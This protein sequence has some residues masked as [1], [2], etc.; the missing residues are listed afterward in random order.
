MKNKLNVLFLLLF[1]SLMTSAQTNRAL[2]VGIDNYPETSG[3]PKIHG[4]NDAELIIPLLK[5]NGYSSKNIIQL[6][7]GQATKANILNAFQKLQTQSVKG[8][9]IYIHFSCHGQQ[10][11]DDD[12]DELDEL[13]EALIPY[14][15]DRRYKKG[16]YEGANH[17]RDD[18][19]ERLLNKIRTKIGATGNIIVVLDACHSGTGTREG[20]DE[21]FIRGTSYI[22]KPDN[23]IK[24]A[25]KKD[26]SKNR[27]I[28]N[29]QMASITV[30]SACKEDEKNYEHYDN[31]PQ[32]HYG[33]LSHALYTTLK[34][35]QT[36]YTSKQLAN[37]LENK[38]KT[39]FNE[40]RWK[41]TP[42]FE[43]TN[44]DNTLKF[45]K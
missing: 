24:P 38:M 5:A 13:D 8:D 35:N 27:L 39:M 32:K 23:Y 42:F 30:F 17:L 7:N 28:P 26:A 9:C 1:I 15:A 6:L 36:T 3:W 44:P 37:I 25:L 10:M 29:P 22:F 41:Q 34:N 16:L 12:G 31:R 21:E 4:A 14:D 18:E 11:A 20:D 19:L 40:K 33:S 43:S 2:F 45:W